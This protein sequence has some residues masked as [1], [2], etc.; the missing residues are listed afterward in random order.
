[1]KDLVDSINTVHAVYI[2][3][4]W[5]NSNKSYA[6]FRDIN[7]LCIEGNY[8]SRT[9]TKEGGV[10]IYIHKVFNSF[11]IELNKRE[12]TFQ[13]TLTE[14]KFNNKKSYILCLQIFF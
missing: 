11:K 12:K 14:L 9:N 3:E 5:W 10:A 13:F 7:L 6:A 8:F 1:M 2:S 4:T